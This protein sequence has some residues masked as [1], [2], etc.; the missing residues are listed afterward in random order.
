MRAGASY[1][2][3]SSWGALDREG[4]LLWLQGLSPQTM[5]AQQWKLVTELGWQGAGA[6]LEWLAA[7]E[8]SAAG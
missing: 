1:R 3:I 2:Y 8:S 5:H 4:A 7:G 6:Q